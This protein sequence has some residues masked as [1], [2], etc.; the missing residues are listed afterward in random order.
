MSR[1]RS[2]GAAVLVVAA[3]MMATAG[4]AEELRRDPFIPL[5]NR[6]GRFLTG[7]KATTTGIEGI[8]FEGILQDPKGS[9]AIINGEVVREGEMIDGYFVKA[10]AP[11]RVILKLGE[12]EYSIPLIQEAPAQEGKRHDHHP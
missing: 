4:R 6:D 7:V 12:K 5:V 10:I 2:A 11:D 9:M 3:T 1:H 8:V